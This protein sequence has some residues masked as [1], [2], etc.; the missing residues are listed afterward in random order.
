MFYYENERA[1]SIRLHT[2]WS[3]MQCDPCEERN[4]ETEWVQLDALEVVNMARSDVVKDKSTRHA[5]REKDRVICTL[6]CGH[7]HPAGDMKQPSVTCNQ[8]TVPTIEHAVRALRLKIQDVHAGC[9]AVAE[10]AR[11][12][13]G[14]PHT[15]PAPDALAALMAA[16]KAQQAASRAEAAVKAATDLRDAA[17]AA[18]EAA[19]R[20]LAAL[21]AAAVQADAELPAAKRQRNQGPLLPW[22]KATAGWTLDD[23]T[24]WEAGE[25][26]RRAVLIIDGADELPPHRGEEGYLHHWHRGLIGA[27]QSWA[28]GCKKHVVQMTMG[29]RQALSL[30]HPQPHTHHHPHASPCTLTPTLRE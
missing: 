2:A 6:W 18:C 16:R 24:K 19:E 10:A 25:Q 8:S 22:Q 15:R 30:L 29:R 17:R 14:G 13:A 26:T 27:V 7:I 12:A 1:L 21:T 9:I 3:T 5:G 20:E 11:A 4:L 28:R 23:W